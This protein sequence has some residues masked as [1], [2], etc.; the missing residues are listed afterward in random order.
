MNLPLVSVI[1]SVY[2]GEKYLV[3][4]IDSILNQ[5]YQNFEFIII[6]DCSTDNSSH[7]LQEYAKK[8]SRIKIIKKEKNIG[9]KGF[10]ENLNLG[11]SIAEGK[12]IARMDADDISLPERFQKQVTFLE[13][14]PE[15][16][17]V[18][19]QIDFINEKNE[20]IGEKAG[21]LEHE[22]IVK[23]L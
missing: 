10:I 16:F 20:I 9:I 14:N 23:P 8:D 3:Q 7:I 11:I 1:M 15:I 19:A 17:M 4:A 22:E 5:T 13:N 18:G 12:Y 21:A 2:N 6:D